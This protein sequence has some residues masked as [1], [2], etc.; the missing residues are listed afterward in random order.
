M[1]AKIEKNQRQM[2]KKIPIKGIEIQ[3]KKILGQNN[4]KKKLKN[5]KGNTS[6]KRQKRKSK[7]KNEQA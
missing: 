5:L 3:R 1:W 2:H 6:K 4:Q 7:H